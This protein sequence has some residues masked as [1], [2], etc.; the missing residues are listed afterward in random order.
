M[1]TGRASLT[2]GF[3]PDWSLESGYRRDFSLFYGATDDVY[4]TDT[5]Y[6]RIGGL[7][8]ARTSLQAGATYSN[9]QTL[10]ASGVNETLNVYGGTLQ[11]RVMLSRAVSATA[12]YYYYYHLYSD[13]GALPEGFPAEYDRHAVRVG[14]SL[15]VPL[16][17]T[18]TPPRLD[19]R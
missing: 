16:A 1:P 14:I 17:G 19:R 5:A 18:S 9:W 2:Y 13:P 3:S 6:L 15:W 12:G 4:A 11:L 10:V 7:L 8:S